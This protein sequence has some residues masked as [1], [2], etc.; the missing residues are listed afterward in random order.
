MNPTLATGWWPLVSDDQGWPP[1]MQP[2]PGHF[3]AST[4][5]E[6]IFFFVAGAAAVVFALPWATRA[7]VRS[8]N[9]VPLLVLASGLLCSLLEPMLDLL[10]HLHWAHNLVPAFTNFGIT[11]PALIPLCYVA[12][13][14]LEAYFSYFVIRNGAHRNVFFMLLG[15][16]IATDALM[17]TIGINLGVYLYYGVQPFTFLNFPY[18]WGF[19]NGGSFVTVGAVLAYAVPRLQ[20]AKKALLLLAA[21]FGMMVAYFGV[22]SIH[23]LALN[24]TIP[25]WMRWVAT[26]TMMVM[27][28][29]WMSI[30]HK[31]VGRP[32]SLPAPKWTVWRVFAYGKLTPNRATRMKMWQKMCEE[33]GVKPSDGLATDPEDP[34][35]ALVVGPTFVGNAANQARAAKQPAAV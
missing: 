7:A 26:A 5:A 22:G 23:V 15:L 9:Y 29:G 32:E 6:I 4:T 3:A 34:K 8:R 1:N 2:A 10:G 31:L 21:P 35:Q 18:W 27:M 30:L 24:S 25:V 12:F 19:I 13:L 11:V 20:G 14:G 17:E 28:V 16:G 33:G